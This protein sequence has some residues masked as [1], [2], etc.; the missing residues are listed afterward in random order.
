MAETKKPPA[1]SMEQEAKDFIKT[2]KNTPKKNVLDEGLSPLRAQLAA[3]VLSGLLASGVRTRAEELV[4]E[5]YR[6]TDLILKY[7]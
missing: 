2:K 1:L 4:D 3:S 7:K 6:Y 5:A